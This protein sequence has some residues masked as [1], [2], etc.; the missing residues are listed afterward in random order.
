[1]P[2]KLAS[3]YLNLC[4]RGRGSAKQCHHQLH[5][6]CSIRK[7]PLTNKHTA[8]T[9]STVILLQVTQ[10][11]P[12]NQ[13]KTQLRYLYL[14]KHPFTLTKQS[15]LIPSKLST[16]MH[17]SNFPPKKIKYTKSVLDLKYM[18][19]HGGSGG[20]QCPHCPEPTARHKKHKIFTT[21]VTIIIVH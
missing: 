3:I 13:M 17:H 2:I 4:D 18:V 15:K 20:K 6:Y 19:T 11:H 7:K 21:H 12:A 14:T 16:Q 9:Q 10:Q 5:L 8:N 1:M